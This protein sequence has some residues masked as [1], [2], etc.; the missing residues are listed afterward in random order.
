MKEFENND[1]QQFDELHPRLPSSPTPTFVLHHRPLRALAPHTFH[2][3]PNRRELKTCLSASSYPPAPLAEREN[4]SQPVPL[5]LSDCLTT[6]CVYAVKHEN[7]GWHRVHPSLFSLT[8]WYRPSFSATQV[9]YWHITVTVNFYL[10][11]ANS[12]SICAVRKRIN[13]GSMAESTTT[14]GRVLKI[15]LRIRTSRAIPSDSIDA[16]RGYDLVP[17]TTCGRNEFLTRFRG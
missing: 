6:L 10:C 1:Q 17:T 9:S 7:D 5:A 15:P 4:L 14:G 16:H 3:E 2:T 12:S 13:Q 11:D 8:A